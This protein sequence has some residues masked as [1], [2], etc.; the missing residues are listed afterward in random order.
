MQKFF[1]SILSVALPVLVWGD[2]VHVYEETETDGVK[3]RISE[4]SLTTGMPWETQAAP[5]KAGYIFTHWSISTA[6]EFVAR[7][8]WGRALDVATFKLYEDTTLTAHYMPTT[9]DSDGDGVADG[10]EFYWYGNLV[11]NGAADTDGDGFTFA[12]ELPR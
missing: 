12:E 7:D 3:V 8:A 4:R 1:F 10:Y 11:Q 2:L 9:Q 6:Q 5:T